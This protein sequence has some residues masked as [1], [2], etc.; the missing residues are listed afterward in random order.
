MVLKVLQEIDSIGIPVGAALLSTRLDIPQAT[1]GRILSKLEKEGYLTKVS[2]KGRLLTEEGL[3][4]LQ[5][6]SQRKLKL[7]TADKLITMTTWKSKDKLLEILQVRKLLECQTAELACINGTEDQMEKLSAI[8]L[9][10]SCEVNNGG[11]GNDQDLKLHMC[12]AEMSKNVTL[13]QML[14][15][16]LTTENAY[17]DFSLAGEH[18]LNYRMNMHEKI[19]NSIKNR[20]VQNARAAMSEHLDQV[21]SDVDTFYSQDEDANHIQ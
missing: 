2:N 11:L 19:V 3:S 17:T 16:L 1:V 15:L 14:S 10:Y 18:V 8:M 5:H 7:K 6:E 12:I 13:N 20:D 4:F 9:G 21:I